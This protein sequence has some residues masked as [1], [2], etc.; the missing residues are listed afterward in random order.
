M[1][2]SLFLSLFHFSLLHPV[3][4]NLL[5]S[6]SVSGPLLGTVDVRWLRHSA[7]QRLA[8]ERYIITN[9]LQV[10]RSL[11]R[12]VQDDGWTQPQLWLGQAESRDL[13]W[14]MRVES[15][16]F[17]RRICFAVIAL[18]EIN[19]LLTSPEQGRDNCFANKHLMYYFLHSPHISHLLPWIICL[20]VSLNFHRKLERATSV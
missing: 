10:T 1:F 13:S 12:C 17:R 2:P 7:C 5:G 11:W 3:R 16:F 6:S 14:S 4:Q 8:G 15:S 18:W 19:F 9:Y 20:P